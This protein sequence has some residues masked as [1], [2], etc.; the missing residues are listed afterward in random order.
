MPPLSGHGRDS[1]LN[2]SR[3]AINLGPGPAAASRGPDRDHWHLSHRVIWHLINWSSNRSGHVKRVSWPRNARRHRGRS[4]LQVTLS[5]EALGFV[6]VRFS[7][8]EL[9]ASVCL[10]CRADWARCR[11]ASRSSLVLKP[12]FGSGW[13]AGALICFCFNFYFRAEQN[14]VAFRGDISSACRSLSVIL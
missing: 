7:C 6:A 5:R 3:W 1:K 2:C 4:S 11:R 8:D 12:K 9:I 14:G 10:G 13:A